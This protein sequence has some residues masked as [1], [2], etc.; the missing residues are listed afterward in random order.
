MINILTLKVDTKYSVNYVNRLYLSMKRNSTVPFK[1]YCY[2]EDPKG[3][4]DDI[5]IVPIKNPHKFKLQWHKIEFH[6]TGFADIP[7]GE[8]CLILD[9]DWI[10][11]NNIDEILS[12]KLP[13]NKLGC[14]ERWWSN[15]RNFCKLNGGFQMYHMGD[16]NEIYIT[17]MQ[18][19][20][21]WQEYF[22]KKGEAEGPVNGEQ[23]FINASR[24]EKCWLPM[25][26]FAKHW[27]VEYNKIQ[28]NW[29]N[30]VNPTE[31]YFI[32]GMFADSIK[33]VHFTNAKNLIHESND[34]WIKDY[35]F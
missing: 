2:T 30:L 35:W 28:K 32:S 25:E 14:F 9:I 31:P 19:P 18:Q 17:F 15:R 29:Q 5:N 23:N 34:E 8:K 4:H 13:K 12:Y 21:F 3:I 26:W 7:I 20:E 1:F 10:I 16:T 6:K 11:I 33:M 27:D 24:V 22:I